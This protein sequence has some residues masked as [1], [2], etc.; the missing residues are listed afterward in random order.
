MRYMPPTTLTTI[1]ALPAIQ[2]GDG[3]KDQSPID[4]PDPARTAVSAYEAD[5]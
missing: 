5:E 1:M 3:L 2:G 4:S